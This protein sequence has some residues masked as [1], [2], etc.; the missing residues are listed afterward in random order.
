MPRC[1]ASRQVSMKSAERKGVVV[2]LP[3][4]SSATRRAQV[5]F[6]PAAIEI[7][8]TPPSPVAGATA[9]IIILFLVTVICWA[10]FGRVD[11][12]PPASGKIVPPGR[13]KLIQPF[14]TGVVRAIHVQDG[15]AVRMG[16]VLV[17]LDTTINAAERD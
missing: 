13:P 3:M 9:P 17:E 6:L 4:S 1:I 2:T 11:I 16:D 5:E 14:E 10:T 8:E 15:Q 7:V 12:I